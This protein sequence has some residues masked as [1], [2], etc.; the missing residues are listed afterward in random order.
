MPALAASSRRARSIGRVL[1]G[2]ALVAL[3]GGCDIAGAPTLRPIPTW[4]VVGEVLPDATSGS[5]SATVTCGGKS[6]PAS[7]LEAPTGAETATG[8]EYDALRAAFQTFGDA[9]PGA[10]GWS[11]RL[12]GRDDSRAIFLARTD[13]LGPP[14]WVD[15]H[16]SLD[17]GEWHADG[18]GQCDPRVVLSADFGPAT[19]ALDPAY[20]APGAETVELHVLVWEQACS[21][22][23]PATGRIS[24]PV[25]VLGGT[26]VTI[27]LGVRPLGGGQTCPGPPGTPATL[28][29]P[30]QLGS[31][32][33]LDG[34][35][36][37]PRAPTPDF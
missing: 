33:L 15:A 17:N 16:V 7:G 19:W 36:I 4:P 20:P 11:W 2:L 18:M 37:P 30:E 5:E 3:V 9:V 24:A 26:T 22:G 34:G 32:T 21:S 14:G 29:L 27:T 28:R 8:P 35:T 13:D 6:F 10:A 12:A 23:S 1:M 25:I 31:R